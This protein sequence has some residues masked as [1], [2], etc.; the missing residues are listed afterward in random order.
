M[1]STKNDWHI[2]SAADVLTALSTSG[3]GLTAADAV[4]RL[5]QYGPN[6]LHEQAGKGPL[7]MLLEQFT[8]TMVLILIVAAVVSGLLGKGMETV[9]IAA[10]VILF[11]LL[12]FA[13]EYRAERAMASLKQLA[14]PVVRVRRDGRLLEISARELVPGDIIVLETG[15]SVP[16]DARLIESVNL[17]I[18]EAT[19]TGESESVEK[20]T[21]VLSGGDLPLG[22]RRNM[23]YLG[24]AATYGRGTAVVVETGMRTELGKIAGMIQQVTAES[25]PL[26][27][28]LDRVGKT[29]AVAGIIVSLLVMLIGVLGGEAIGNMFLTAVSV[30]VA[31]VPEGLPAVITITLAI[32]AQRMLRRNALV[33]KLPAVETLGSVDIICSDKT[34]TLTEN[35]MTVTVI[36]VA[37]ERLD[38]TETLHKRQPEVAAGE[39]KPGSL[40]Q[41]SPAIRL[42]LVSGALCND[43]TLKP[44]KDGGSLHAIGD[45]TEGA[46]VVAAAQAG[47]L[48][49]DLDAAMP[50]V[51]EFPFDSDR[52]R[53]TTV[54][55]LPAAGGAAGFLPP[56]GDGSH[57]AFSKG[58][59]DG[60]LELASHVWTADKIEPMTADFR[61]R[62]LAAAE[63]MAKQGVR[64]LGI[65]CRP[66]TGVPVDL[67]RELE[68][69]LILV[70]L[71]G[72]MDPPRAAARTAVEMCRA[73]GIR[74]VMI[75]G[76][77]ALTAA[78]IAQYL[79]IADNPEVVTGSMLNTM[80]DA[81]LQGVAERTS[82]Y[83][84]VSPEDKLRIVN[85]L[86]QRGHVIAMTGD[87]V[88]DSP[89]LKK[90]DIGVAMGIAG[91]D[92]AK[93]ASAM[94]LLD[95]NFATIVAAVREGRIIYDNLLRFIKFSLGGNLGKVLVMLGAPLLGIAVALRPLQLLWLNLLTDGLMGLG[96]GF[97]PGET[98]VM[99]RP[100]RTPNSPI[101]D[102]ATC[103]HIGWVGVLI[104]VLALG[105][106]A[107]YFDPK[108]L[109]DTRWQTLLFASLGFAQMGQALGLRAWGHSILSIATN[110]MMAAVFLVTLVLQLLP[111]YVP[112][113][114]RFFG[115]TPLSPVELAMTLSLGVLTFAIVRAEKAL[116]RI[117]TR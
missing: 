19:L 24:T 87:G 100:P 1:S 114:T 7:R 45:P 97:E 60:L 22:D 63:G 111:I 6:E 88:N 72:L 65:A 49:D 79:T 117:R 74:P 43:A 80:S 3:N 61:S 77:H 11:G 25:T 90:A 42:T 86:Q 68:R 92:V 31:V 110:P 109:A 28:Q 104:G 96:L 82:V 40:G 29:L 115:L 81:D 89:A 102:R 51:A 78:A 53:M 10:I 95:D 85:A 18:Q 21:A 34:G 27:K 32:G 50:R 17:R 36:A 12:G 5:E 70:G 35:R 101:L 103:V 58:A 30:A 33:R 66:L 47:L 14:V 16:A 26:Q 69:D 113:L 105:L 4:A 52:K 98:D 73:A 59:I 57:V 106:G 107:A 62:I 56:L 67:T 83:A 2:R 8:Q 71:V 48:K 55:R 112:A 23:I 99:N 76:D 39:L 41:I 84:R 38:L 93:E 44:G 116:R 13:S 15:N 64:V 54:H 46:L 94:V 9:A 108:N 75:T 20:S 37:G 91:T